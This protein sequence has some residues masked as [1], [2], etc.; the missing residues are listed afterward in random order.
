MDKGLV[1]KYGEGG[2][3]GASEVLPLP[4]GGAEKVLAM[5]KGGGGGG[6]TSF[7]VVL[8]WELEVLAIVMGVRE[9]LPPFKKGGGRKK[10]F[11][12]S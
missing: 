2:G 11:K 1:T 6:T 3:G 5:L 9:K 12:L 10:S 8:T 7:E 4:K